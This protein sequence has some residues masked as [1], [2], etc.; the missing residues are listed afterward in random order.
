MAILQDFSE[1]IKECGVGVFAM[2][3]IALIAFGSAS[4][5][6][7]LYGTR[8]TTS[9]TS[10]QISIIYPSDPALVAKYKPIGGG[11]TNNSLSTKTTASHVKPT[12]PSDIQAA[13]VGSING[14]KYYPIG[15]SGANRIKPEN[16]ILFATQ[17]EAE[18]SGYTQSTGCTY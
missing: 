10:N 5:A 3:I 9:A 11:D 8:S 15:C 2:E 4:F 13:Y 6:L 16:Q 18:Q 7:G 14:T 12:A 1:K 17:D